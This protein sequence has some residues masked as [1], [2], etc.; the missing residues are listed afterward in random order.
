M[1]KALGR[2]LMVVVVPAMLA[3][4]LGDDA[5]GRDPE[6]TGTASLAL[7]GVPADGTCIVLEARGNRTVTR[8]IDAPAGSMMV[9]SLTGLPLG[10]VTFSASA[11]ASTCANR[12]STP[13]TWLSDAAFTI[14]IAVSPPA[15]V[16]LNLVRNG[17]ANVGVGF[18]DDAPTP[19][20]GAPSDGGAGGPSAA[21]EPLMFLQLE[22]LT[23]DS[24]EPGLVGSFDL[25]AFNLAMSST[26]TASSGGGSGA[27]KATFTATAVTK[28]QKGVPFIY[29]TSATGKHLRTATVT[30]KK[31]K[32]DKKVDYYVVTLSDVLISL[33][34]TG[35]ATPD[36]IADVTLG[37]SFA[38]ISIAFQNQSPDGTPGPPTVFDWDLLRNAGSAPGTY[39]F[40]F[41]LGG[42]PT[43]PAKAI[44][45]FRAPSEQNSTTV[46][47]GGSGVGKPVFSDAVVG[48]D[49]DVDVIKYLF[50]GTAGRRTAMG[51]V[52]LDVAGP[53]GPTPFASYGFKEI[54]ITG[55]T[56]SGPDAVVS[57][58]SVLFS[59]ST[60]VPGGPTT[61]TMYDTRTGKI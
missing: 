33:V 20:G 59:W 56:L 23:G 17:R 29:T 21:A 30:V 7:T 36:A 54:F 25:S 55:V 32:G 60:F 22:S 45:V 34:S 31:K 27:G 3:G 10:Q 47:G 39:P 26:T 38:A 51:S 35:P 15:T 1:V 16:T 4:C 48:L 44:K 13:A 9:V 5:P 46:G 8:A 43:A 58:S 49:V 18:N 11:F 41:I 52:E 61:T 42:A 28:Y 12:G 57:F 53:S 2:M 40:D 24:T 6:L 14:T 37:F 19:D 50:A